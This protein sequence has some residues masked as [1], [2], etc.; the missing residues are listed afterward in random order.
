MEK[1]SLAQKSG[2][3]VEVWLQQ[4]E[5]HHINSV[6]NQIKKVKEK[7]LIFKCENPELDYNS[8]IFDYIDLDFSV[9][10]NSVS[11]F[12]KNYPNQ[13]IL[14]SFHDFNSTPDNESLDK[15]IFKMENKGAEVF[16][17]ATH[18]NTFADS[19][20]MMS[21]LEELNNK[22]KR[23]ICLCM[24]EKGKITRIIGHL[25]GNLLMYAPLTS[26]ELTAP[27]QLTCEQ[28]KSYYKLIE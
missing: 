13:K 7:P 6:I 18:A 28:M 24:G 2:D 22:G 5:P 11:K 16:K 19:L 1:F 21:I 9:S 14:L 4:L 3:F 26:D 27:G 15:I 23:A 17:L 8:E 10:E 25:F 20:R 12:K